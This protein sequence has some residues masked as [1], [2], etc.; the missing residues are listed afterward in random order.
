MSEGKPPVLHGLGEEGLVSHLPG[1]QIKS[2][3]Q[4]LWM[5]IVYREENVAFSCPAVRLGFLFK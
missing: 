2:L 5:E 4:S 1:G 3:W